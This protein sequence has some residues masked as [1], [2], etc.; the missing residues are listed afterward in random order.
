M[1]KYGETTN[2]SHRYTKKYL[3][4]NNAEMQIEIQGTKREM[5]QW[6]HEQIL[7]YKNINNEL[8]PPLNKSDY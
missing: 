3:Q 2:S 4:N 5:H 6:Q 7:D 8:R 1:L